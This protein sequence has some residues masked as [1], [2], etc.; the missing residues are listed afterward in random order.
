MFHAVG[1]LVRACSYDDDFSLGKKE[2]I[3]LFEGGVLSSEV[4]RELSMQL[5][6]ARLAAFCALAA[7]TRLEEHDWLGVL[8]MIKSAWAYSPSSTEA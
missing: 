2:L 5:T 7:S 1:D 6:G 3:K 4:L 8:V